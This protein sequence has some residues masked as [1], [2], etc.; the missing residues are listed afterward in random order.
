[1]WKIAE[2]LMLR[3]DLIEVF[4]RAVVRLGLIPEY[5]IWFGFYILQFFR[6]FLV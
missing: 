1:M 5:L 4:C 6:A 3:P 2:V